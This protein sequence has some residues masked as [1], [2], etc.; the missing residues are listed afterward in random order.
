[1]LA[2]ALTGALGSS[3]AAAPDH[4]QPAERTHLMVWMVNSDGANFNAL[5]TGVVGDYGSAE[6]VLPDGT[7]DPEHS[8]ELALNL[9][10]GSFRLSI[11]PIAH[12]LAIA[13]QR[14]TSNPGNCSL[15]YHFTAPAPVVPG[16]G[17][18]AYQGI[19]GGFAVTVELDE[20]HPRDASGCELTATPLSE[21]VV[22][23]GTGTVT[24]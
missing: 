7:V 11:V 8:S 22:L 12:D 23:D 13:Q 18:G 2:A 24:P 19:T 14:A 15:A 21:L 16:T 20:V 4:Q 5:A 10:R 3:A 17:T 1:M 9:A 6:T